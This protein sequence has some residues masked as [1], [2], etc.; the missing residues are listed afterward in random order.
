[1]MTFIGLSNLAHLPSL[2][3]RHEIYIELFRDNIRGL[4]SVLR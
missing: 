2:G 4:K 1:M 3:I